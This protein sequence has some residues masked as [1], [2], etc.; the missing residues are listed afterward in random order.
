MEQTVK[1]RKLQAMET[2]KKIFDATMELVKE[3]GI[4]DVQIEEISRRAGVSIGLFYKY[5]TNK[6][7]V[8]MEAKVR[9]LDDFY[10]SIRESFLNGPRG[11]EKIFRFVWHIMDHHENKLSKEELKHIYTT[12]L[13]NPGRG[14]SIVTEKRPIYLGFSEGLKEMAEDGLLKENVS[15]E[16]AT[17]HM[18]MLIRG[19]IFEYLLTDDPF[20][21]IGTSKLLITTYLKGLKVPQDGRE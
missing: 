11:E 9:E 2:K 16:M 13:S 12:I 5:Y 14:Q 20:D 1:K 6:S 18:V 7:D 4:E 3:K 19:M 17:R 8:I 10:T 21:L 15:V